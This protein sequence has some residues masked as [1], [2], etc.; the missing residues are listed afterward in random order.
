MMKQSYNEDWIDQIRL[1]IY[2]EIKDMTSEER[3][4][5]F[6]SAGERIAQKYGVKVVPSRAMPTRLPRALSW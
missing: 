4:E 3:T 5:Y 2:E 1:E 6:R